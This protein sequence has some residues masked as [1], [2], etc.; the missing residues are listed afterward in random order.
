MKIKL[1]ILERDSS[2]LNRIVSV[3][4]MKYGE[5]FEIYSFTD[6]DVALS[7]LDPSKIDVLLADDSFEIDVAMLPSRC[8]LAYLVENGDIESV[9]EQRAIF[10]FQKVELIYKQIL[11]VYAE[12][13]NDIGGVNFGGDNCKLYVFSSPGGGTG[14][15]SMAAACALHYARAGKKTIYLN[16]ETFGGADMFFT[17]E[18]QFDMSD[19][20][21]AVK[22]KKANLALKLESCVRQDEQ[23]VCFYAQS[24]IALDMMELG[25]EDILALVKELQMT[26]SYDYIILDMDFAADKNALSIF[27]KSHAMILVGD[28]SDLSNNKI[29]RA[30]KAIATMEQNADAPLTGRMALMYNKFSSKTSHAMEELGVRLLGGAPRYEHATPKQVVN[31]LAGMDMFDQIIRL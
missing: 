3:F 20:I 31:Q 30:Y 17:A 26:G 24:Q 6:K 28:G 16:L 10:K 29:Q 22:S 11:S 15:S 12:K 9:R 25:T 14:S 18:G 13:A 7:T 5:K 19:V 27:R 21:Y 4:N 23:G 2:Y 8:G 1:A